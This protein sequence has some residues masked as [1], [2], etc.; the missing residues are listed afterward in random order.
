MIRIL[1]CI[2]TAPCAEQRAIVHSDIAR[3]IAHAFGVKAGILLPTDDRVQTRVKTQKGWLS[4]QEY[5]VREKCVPQV[6][7]LEF[8]GISEARPTDEALTAIAQADLIVIAPSN[9]LVSIDPI[10]FCSGYSG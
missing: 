7:A 3:D 8:S 10:S 4:F 5:F 6:E 2:S 1:A 9:P